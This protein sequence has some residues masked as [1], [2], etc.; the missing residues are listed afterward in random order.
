MRFTLRYLSTVVHSSV[1]GARVRG[2]RL[3]DFP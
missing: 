2:V 3:E 1:P